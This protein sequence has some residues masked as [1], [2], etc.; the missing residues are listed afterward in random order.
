MMVRTSWND[1]PAFRITRS[2]HVSLNVA[3]LDA[4]VAFYEG[5]VGL[6]VSDRTE[7][8][9]WLRALEEASHHSLI[10]TTT[11]A[12]GTAN[13]VGFHVEDDEDIERAAR[14]LTG[15]GL[16][17]ER[18]EAPYQGPTLR[19]SDPRGVAMELTSSVDQ[20]ERLLQRYETYRAGHLMRIDHFQVVTDD[21]QASTDFYADLGFRMAEYTVDAK[22][23][24][25][26]GSWL[27]VKGNTHDLVFTS[28][29]GP[30]LHHFAYVVPDAASLIHACDVLGAHEMGDAIDRGP[31]RHGISNA[32]FVYFRDPDGHRIEL[33]TSHY[34]FI[35]KE[36]PPLRWEITD[37]R[38][39]QLWG[40]PASE[41]W[42]FEASPF[43]DAEVRE[44]RLQSQVPTLERYLGLH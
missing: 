21:V 32:L 24:T 10:L 8:T 34:Q 44:P 30:R 37:P 17:P 4:S 23:D 19:F 33:F 7:D 16:R 25:L 27:E 12:P 22:D 38:R 26:W 11:G 29:R 42:F 2:S 15:L 6:H 28:G 14:H 35:D 36:T 43:G 20:S 18:I 5:V 1:N 9:V 40:M 41:R 13:F 3:D 31:G 39:A